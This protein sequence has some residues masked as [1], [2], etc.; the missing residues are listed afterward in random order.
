MFKAAVSLLINKG[1]DFQEQMRDGDLTDPNFREFIVREIDVVMKGQE[2]NRDLLTATSS[3]RQGIVHL[4]KM[5]EK[6][7][8][9]DSSA[10]SPITALAKDMKKLKVRN[11]DDENKRVLSDAKE[12]F[13]EARSKATD[14]FN[15]EALR[16]ADRIQAMVI[17]VAA[18]IMRRVDHLEAALE[19]CKTC[20]DELHSMPDVKKFT[21][22]IVDSRYVPQWNKKERM[23]SISIVCQVNRVIYDVTKTV[24]KDAHLLI[25]PPVVISRRLPGP[26]PIMGQDNVDPLRDT[27][28]TKVLAEQGM[29]HCGVTLWSFGMEGEELHKLKE[30]WGIASNRRGQFIVSDYKEN[31]V[32][33]Y[34][35]DGKFLHAFRPPPRT[36]IYDVA[37]DRN[38][39]IYVLTYMK[40]KPEDEEWT[41]TMSVHDDSTKLQRTF[42]LRKG[43]WEGFYHVSPLAVNDRNKVMVLGRLHSGKYGKYVVDVYET[44]G[45]FV[46]SFGEEIFKS[47]SAITAASDG[48]IMIVQ[49]SPPRVHALSEQ[50]DHL[51]TFPLTWLS[52]RLSPHIAFHWASENVIVADMDDNRLFMQINTKDGKF[53]RTIYLGGDQR[54]WL[55]GITVTAEEGRIAITFGATMLPY[56]KVMVL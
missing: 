46:R 30:P 39:N 20:L 6:E 44:D 33:V 10:E 14:A 11:L 54:Y 51:F 9:S 53:V 26:L 50:G 43:A 21:E 45:R 13:K 16:V 5:F 35:K 15:K 28:V 18:T 27:R 47:A 37:T 1:Q 55:K 31:Q 41:L 4:F 8:I 25:W 32:K 29:E 42:N 23:D 40:E 34:D 7:K 36:H 24:G 52:G 17:R 19:A 38:D 48:R 56:G 22:Q 3:F 12:A 49:S 2:R